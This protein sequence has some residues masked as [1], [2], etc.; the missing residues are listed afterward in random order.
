MTMWDKLNKQRENGG[1]KDEDSSNNV[2]L[3]D[4]KKGL[5]LILSILK[6]PKNKKESYKIM[7]NLDYFDDS[8]R[9]INIEN[10]IRLGQSFKTLS[11][12]QIQ[13]S[14]F[15]LE[16]AIVGIGGQFSSG[17]SAFINTLTG[18]KNIQLPENQNP[19]TAIATYLTKGNKDSFIEIYAENGNRISVTQNALDALTH[20]FSKT[21]NMGFSQVI[22]HIKI[23]LPNFQ[24]DNI[25]LLDTPGYS[26][27]GQGIKK[28]A[29]DS[30]K[31][32]EQLRTAD[33]LIWLIDSDNGGIKDS[34]IRFINKML[35]KSPI[36]FVLTKADKKINDIQKIMNETRITLEKNRVNVYDIIIHSKHGYE[37]DDKKSF[38]NLIKTGIKKRQ[39][40]LRTAE[41]NKQNESFVIGEMKGILRTITKDIDDKKQI[42]IDNNSKIRRSVSG[43]QDVLSIKSLG[44]LYSQNILELSKYETSKNILLKKINFTH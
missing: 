11:K 38:Q 33:H 19:T 22:K 31:A 25:A 7:R 8:L 28:E 24:Y 32:F 12:K 23:S 17:K 40:F 15:L 4:P 39:D 3:S 20:E 30:E 41:K 27:P 13:Q 44:Y 37:D 16:K 2:Y 9:Q 43:I 36:L 42:L 1:N 21:Y 5:E 14:D 6:K 10:E 26:K 18:T 34:D 35:I 29:R